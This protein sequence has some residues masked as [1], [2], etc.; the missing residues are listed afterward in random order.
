MVTIEEA[1]QRPPSTDSEQPPQLAASPD[2]RFRTP[3]RS[4]RTRV[5]TFALWALRALVVVPLVLMGPELVS[6]IAGRPGAVA[7]VSQSTADILGTSSML[8]MVLML[9]VTPIQTMTG[10][11]WHLALR[12][13]YGVAMFLSAAL[14]LIL[15]ALTTGDTFSG[16]VFGRIGGHSFLVVG[17][18]AVLL[19]LPLVLTANRRAHRWLGSYWKRLHRLVYVIWFLVMV[20]LLLLFGFR[21]I[22]LQALVVSV[23]LVLLRLPPVRKWWST[24]R[25]T[26]QHRILRGVLAL[27]LVGTF[28]AGLRPIIAELSFKGQAAFVQKPVD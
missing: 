12:R 5:E 2:G 22:F 18:L 25:R 28:A 24:A 20:H 4:G 8:L 16:G 13:D 14:D 6:L 15:A 7:N 3:D 23:P 19:L 26:H 1:R 21:G 27:A 9:T 11:T 10:W 17:T